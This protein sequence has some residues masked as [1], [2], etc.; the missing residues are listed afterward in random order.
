MCMF[1]AR[2]FSGTVQGTNIIEHVPEDL[3]LSYQLNFANF[4]ASS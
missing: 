2:F 3:D 1:T 4:S